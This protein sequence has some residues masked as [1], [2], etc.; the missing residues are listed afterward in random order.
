VADA[1]TY[2]AIEWTD[3][4]LRD[5]ARGGDALRHVALDTFRAA[6]YGTIEGSMF[7][8]RGKLL[9]SVPVN[10]QVAEVG[11]DD[12]NTAVDRAIDKGVRRLSLFFAE[13]VKFYENGILFP[14]D[15]DRVR[16]FTAWRQIEHAEWDDDTITIYI[17]AQKQPLVVVPSASLLTGY[18]SLS[19]PVRAGSVRVPAE[20]RGQVVSLLSD[21]HVTTVGPSSPS[22]PA[23]ATTFPSTQLSAEDQSFRDS[24]RGVLKLWIVMLAST[25]LSFLII[26]AVRPGNRVDNPLLAGTL[27]GVAIASALA[28]FVARKWFESRARIENNPRLRGAGFLLAMVFC[29]SASLYGVMSWFLTA[30]RQSYLCILIGAIAMLIHYPKGSD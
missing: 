25:V 18:G 2:K 10:Y 17:A 11:R 27:L 23:Q 9:F 1:G 22:V 4:L 8:H 29:E 13:T 20:R 26:Q 15:D 7:D 14:E 28:S 6:G 3:D 24:R 12:T 21:A 16:L 5:Q 30:S 19:R